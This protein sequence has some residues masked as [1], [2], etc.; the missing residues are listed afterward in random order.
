MPSTPSEAEVAAMQQMYSQYLSLYVQ[1]LQSQSLPQQS[2][3]LLQQNFHYQQQFNFA[4]LNAAPA[5]PVVG[6][7][8]PNAAMVMNAG[9]A[10]KIQD[11][12]G[13]DKNRDILDWVFVMTRVLLLFIVIYFHSSFLRL[14]FVAGLCFIVY[15][16]QNRRNGRTRARAQ[17]P[18]PAPEPVQQQQQEREQ[19]KENSDETVDNDEND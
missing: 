11:V 10:G 9:A 7:G 1:Y 19:A 4:E 14:A 16:Y 8:A 12:A 3:V 18:Q 17:N 13:G 5:A 6:E 15:L 2:Q